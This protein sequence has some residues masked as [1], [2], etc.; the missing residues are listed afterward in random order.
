M[1]TMPSFEIGVTAMMAH[2]VAMDAISQNIANVRT[3]G[4]RRAD[5][6]FS[7]LLSGIGTGPYKPGGVQA[8]TRRLVDIEGAIEQTDRPL[9][10]ALNGKGFFVYSSEPTG[11]GDI[12]YSRK[13]SLFGTAIDNE[14]SVGSYLSAFEDKYLM[15]WA[16]DAS[17]NV[18][19]DSVGDMIAIPASLNDPF[20]GRATTQ[21]EI[22]LEIPAVGS[23]TVSTDIGYFDASG[24]PGTLRL[25]WTNTGVNTWD[26]QVSDTA[27]SPLGAVQTMTFD[28]D[29]ALTS[30]TTVDA[31]GLF[32]LDVSNVFQR[33]S[34]FYR[35]LYTQD[36]LEA[37]EFMDYA[38]DRTGLVSGRFSSG[39][40]SPLYQ[41]PVAIFANVNG[42]IELAENLWVEGE[43]SGAAEYRSAGELA[44]V[45]AG[46][47]E[48]S[49]VDL[50]D[51]FTQL[52]VTQRAYSSAAQLVRTTDEM[53]ETIRDL[54]R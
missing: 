1:S 8:E 25:T 37:G 38:V 41:L 18:V 36:G 39:A 28:G 53:L 6:T 44:T 3:P 50:A 4:Y 24:Q 2:S 16:I 31:G 11:A 19:G 52:I 7:T 15:A 20:P 23:S 49:N 13:G 21:A 46:S 48:A 33:G 47:T 27:G 9:D 17:G 32:P 5:T 34:L 43:N 10:L 35:G 30:A 22:G 12:S 40:V 14:A 51:A 54:R 26:L 42:L 45:F 29:G